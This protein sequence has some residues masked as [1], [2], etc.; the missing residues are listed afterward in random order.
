MHWVIVFNGIADSCLWGFEAD[1][2]RLE[3]HDPACGTLGIMPKTDGG[4]VA[5]IDDARWL[6]DALAF[7]HD[8]PVGISPAYLTPW[9]IPEPKD[10]AARSPLLP[11]GTP[12]DSLAPFFY[13]NSVNQGYGAAAELRFSGSYVIRYG[14][15]ALAPSTNFLARFKGRQE[16]VGLYAMAARQADPLAE[17][18]CLYRV[19]EARNGDNGMSCSETYL[20]LLATHDFGELLMACDG[21]ADRAHVNVFEAYRGRALQ[22]LADLEAAGVEDMP[23]YLYG[24]R[25]SLA[26]GKHNVLISR[27]EDRATA[28]SRA[29]AIVKL[30]ARLVVEPPTEAND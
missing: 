1:A 15:D 3:Y 4:P 19:L 6:A 22:E 21:L 26:H 24:I 30:L 11:V 20:P 9:P 23:G 14:E 25:N 2:W 7:D 16:W 13:W 29:L 18:L 10:P 5:S 27:H 28:A 17:Y 12:D 8:A